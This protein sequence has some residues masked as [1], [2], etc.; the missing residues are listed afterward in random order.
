MGTCSRGN[1][2][3]KEGEMENRHLRHITY[4]PGHEQQMLL[5]YIL[6]HSFFKKR[7][8]VRQ[9]L[10]FTDAQNGVQK[11]DPPQVTK[12]VLQMRFERVPNPKAR[13]HFTNAGGLVLG[14]VWDKDI[15][16]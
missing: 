4:T 10:P 15:H 9:H 2:G 5:T 7:T 14:A 11:T 1:V 3:E 8:Q 12:H 16:T 13:A 6:S